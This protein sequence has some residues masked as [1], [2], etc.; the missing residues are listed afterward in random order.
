[1]I[2]DEVDVVLPQKYEFY[3]LS[4]ILSVVL[5]RDWEDNVFVKSQPSYSVLLKLY[6]YLHRKYWI[7]KNLGGG[8]SAIPYDHI[9]TKVKL[10]GFHIGFSHFCWK[11]EQLHRY[12]NQAP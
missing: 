4:Q 1:M 10:T 5:L 2:V 11:S 8:D 12:V 3:I 9:E 7:A 6:N